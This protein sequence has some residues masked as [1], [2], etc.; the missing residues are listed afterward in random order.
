MGFKMN[1][2]PH[3]MGTIVGSSAF[4]QKLQPEPKQKKEG[5]K[6]Q[7]H[8]TSGIPENLYDANGDA[9]STVDID[10]GTLSKIKVEKGTGRK[11]VEVLAGKRDGEFLYLSKE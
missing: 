8:T 6:E 7:T 5:P 9:V 4:K 1:G 10:E 11:Y 2:S 3:K